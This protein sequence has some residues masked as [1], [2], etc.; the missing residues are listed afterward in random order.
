MLQAAQR[1]RPRRTAEPGS[2][3]RRRSRPG[4]PTFVI[5]GG[6]RA[7]A[8]PT[9]ATSRTASAG[10]STG[11]R[12]DPPAVPPRG[13]ARRLAR[14]Y[15]GIAGRGA[16]WLAR[17][18]GGQRSRVQIPPARRDERHRAREP[19]TRVRSGRILTVP[20][21]ISR[22]DPADPAVRVPDRPTATRRRRPHPVRAGGGDGLGR[23]RRRPRDRTGVG[24]RQ[25]PRPG[26]RPAGDRR[27]ADRAR[28]PRRVPAVGGAADPRPR[29]RG[30]GRRAR[31]SCPRRVRLD[32][33]LHRQGRHVH[34]DDRRS[35]DRV[36]EPRAPARRRRARGRLD[37]FAVGIVE[38]YVAAG[39]YVGDMRRALADA[40]GRQPAASS[41]RAD[42]A[43]TGQ[44]RGDARED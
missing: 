30:P 8:A 24:A 42:G 19:A 16:A 9:S 25:D 36:G 34:A 7:R 29:R 43:A 3:T 2:T 4:P 31:R 20:N 27:G 39:V 33:R 37:A 28:G 38:Y 23:R 40:R 1:E 26:G 17:L 14:R 5:F 18:S 12:P 10:P 35:R 15:D 6:R 13:E 41:L 21:L 44:P 22:P 11:R 32:V